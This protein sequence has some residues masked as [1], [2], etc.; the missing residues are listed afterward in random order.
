MWGPGLIITAK[1]SRSQKQVLFSCLLHLQFQTAKMLSNRCPE[2]TKPI[3]LCFSSSKLPKKHLHSFSLP[4][5]HC[6]HDGTFREVQA[7]S[8]HQV[9]QYNGQGRIN[10]RTTHPG[11]LLA[12]RHISQSSEAGSA[13]DVIFGLCLGLVL[14]KHAG[15]H[16]TCPAK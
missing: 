9:R 11:K 15:T 10:G 5:K 4:V 6:Y 7:G 2:D 16:S 1:S 8:L 14:E 12:A 3:E 13:Q